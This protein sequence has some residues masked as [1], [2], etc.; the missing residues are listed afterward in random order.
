MSVSKVRYGRCNLMVV[1]EGSRYVAHVERAISGERVGVVV[2]G[3]SFEEAVMNAK[4]EA[5]RAGG[6]TETEALP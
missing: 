4:L 1:R 6:P 2:A 5:L 3:Q